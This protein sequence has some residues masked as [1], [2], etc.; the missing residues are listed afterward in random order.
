[1]ENREFTIPVYVDVSLEEV[2]EKLPDFL[3]EDEVEGAKLMK[4][5]GDNGDWSLEIEYFKLIAE[6]IKLDFGYKAYSL[7]QQ[8]ISIM[9]NGK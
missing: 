9:E 5:F 4:K 8:V 2:L 7:M 6:S 3:Q 1:M